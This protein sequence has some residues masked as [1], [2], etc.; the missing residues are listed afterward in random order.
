MK[1]IKYLR[2]AMNEMRI[3]DKWKITAVTA[4]FPLAIAYG[5]LRDV[6]LT[7]HNEELLSN[8]YKIEARDK[9]GYLKVLADENK[10]GSIDKNEGE[11]MHAR[12]G[13][14]GLYVIAIDRGTIPY[15]DMK[16]LEPGIDRAIEAYETACNKY[17]K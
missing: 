10:D 14:S 17:S 1:L 8:P 4:V 12:M 3:S 6:Q 15:A 9:F 11:K 16:Q 5:A 13:S 2:N 7:R